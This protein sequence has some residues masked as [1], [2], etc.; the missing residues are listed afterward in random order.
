M[1]IK[2]KNG[3]VTGTSK[4]DKI[5]WISSKDWKKAL[6]V[7][8]GGGNDVINFKK[9]KYKNKLNGQAGND[10]IYGGTSY[11][12]IHGNAG[13][14]V[15][16]GYNGTD[17]LYG[18]DGVDK[19]YGGNGNDY[20]YG[21]KGNDLLDGGANNDK[22]YG[23]YGTNTLKGGAGNDSIYGGTGAD[24]IYAGTGS[25]YI[26]A[27]KGTNTLYFGSNEGTNTVVKGGGTDIIYFNKTANLNNITAYYSDNNLI[28]N[29]SGTTVIIKDYKLG[30]HSAKYIQAG[31]TKKTIASFLDTAI[32]VVPPSPYLTVN[33]TRII[34]GTDNADT[35]TSELG[36]NRIYAGSGNDNITTGAG[37]NYV[38]GGTG[39][40]T[41]TCG[42]ETDIIYG[43]GGEN[44]IYISKG[45]GTD[46]TYDEN[47]NTFV[48]KDITN[49]DSLIFTGGAQN[50]LGLYADLTIT[51]YGNNTDSLTI[52]DFFNIEGYDYSKIKLQAGT[53]GEAVSLYELINNSD[54]KKYYFTGTYKP[55]HNSVTTS[56]AQKAAQIDSVLYGDAPGIS[57]HNYLLGTAGGNNTFY[58]GGVNEGLMGHTNGGITYIIGGDGDETF[59]A[60]G[61]KIYYNGQAYENRE[62]L[63]VVT[64]QDGTK[65][66]KNGVFYNTPLAYEEPYTNYV[67]S[68]G[69]SYPVYYTEDSNKISQI[70]EHDYEIKRGF[71]S[72]NSNNIVL[73]EYIKSSTG[74]IDGGKGNDTFYTSS[75]A[76]G[77]DGN[78]TL[79]GSGVM[80]GNRGDDKFIVTDEYDMVSELVPMYYVC[81]NSGNDYIDTTEMS[82]EFDGTISIIFGEGVNTLKVDGKH[83]IN[84]GIDTSSTFRE[85]EPVSKFIE[86]KDYVTDS[87]VH[88][89]AF[90][91]DNK[92]YIASNNGR[93]AGTLIIDGWGQLTDEQKDKITITYK[94]S[95]E[96]LS[97]E[98]STYTLR[99][100]LNVINQT[101]E[102]FEGD[103]YTNGAHKY[104]IGNGA[105]I[106]KKETYRFNVIDNSNGALDTIT[107]GET[108]GTLGTST[109]ANRNIYDVNQEITGT[110]PKNVDYYIIGGSGAQVIKGGDG[111]DVIY[112]NNLN[113]HDADGNYIYAAENDGNDTIYGGKG[114]DYIIGGS[115]NDFIDG[116]SGKDYID[117][118]EGD[119][120]LIGGT[121]EALDLANTQF[122]YKEIH[123]GNGN[124]TIYSLGAYS[125]GNFDAESS[126]TYL[127]GDTYFTNNIYAGSGND[128]IHAN[129]YRDVVYGGK[130]NDTIYSYATAID[131]YYNSNATSEIYGEEG[132]DSIILKSNA[133]VRAYGGDGDDIIDGSEATA[134]YY[135]MLWGDNGNDTIY[136][137]NSWDIIYTGLGNNYVEAGAG[138]DEIHGSDMWLGQGEDNY[139]DAGDGNDYIRTSGTST[140]F[141]GAGN[142]T[143]YIATG[144]ANVPSNLLIDG[145]AGDDKYIADGEYGYDTIVASSGNDVIE[146]KAFVKTNTSYQYN[147]NDLVLSYNTAGLIL[148]DYASGGFS[149]FTIKTYDGYAQNG[150][151]TMADFISYLNGSYSMATEG[152]EGDDAISSTGNINGLGGN[153]FIL[154]HS[155]TSTEENPQIINTGS[156]NNSVVAMA[157]Y[158]SITGG[159][160][161]DE[162]NIQ[163]RI[164][165]L[166]DN[167]GNNTITAAPQGNY[168]YY[169]LNITLN[170]NGDNT[171]TSTENAN[172]SYYEINATG[173]GKQTINVYSVG[174]GNI[175]I[176]DGNEYINRTLKTEIT[177]GSGNDDITLFE[178]I[179][180]SGIGNDTIAVK[181]GAGSGSYNT[182]G[183]ILKGEDGN[184]TYIIEGGHD[185][186]GTTGISVNSKVLI[187]DT[188]GTNDVK[189]TSD[190]MTHDNLNLLLNVKADGTLEEFK[191]YGDY[192]LETE[193][194]DI[195]GTGY[196]AF[197]CGDMD[198]KYAGTVSTASCNG[199]DICDGVRFANTETV[200]NLSKIEAADGYYISSTTLSSI[201][202][203]AATWLTA[204][205]REYASVWDAIKPN[206]QNDFNSDNY[207]ALYAIFNNEN[208]W[209]QGV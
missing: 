182:Y 139:I 16:Y 49:L 143:I 36:T 3:K 125:E 7:N 196:S 65:E 68:F 5:T 192:N 147:G 70:R 50:S 98:N 202:E 73:V 160:G 23:N 148:K 180:N 78:D 102:L 155:T 52:K 121:V 197:I 79:K 55:K 146:F 110:V 17:H 32:P 34:S 195:T 142:D 96:W 186:Q 164:T 159:T 111:N 66:I 190:F 168:E 27:G 15:I 91:K 107:V 100:F 97:N 118:G 1:A 170:G 54:L 187:T 84:I 179:V 115:G 76:N 39:N 86:T 178:G 149:N 88:F 208:T 152:T 63:I 126:K 114:N 42:S 6:T 153:D 203:Q 108:A 184:D 165:T 77:G 181:D 45:S 71:L 56:P 132:N 18:D 4:K 33:G 82:D 150:Q 83:N 198:L 48:F 92:L 46:V 101:G 57:S 69:E 131:T 185:W 29:A 25:D 41:I 137:S 19:L 183:A 62:Y 151:Y 145:G 201:M 8:A 87:N 127:G 199:W 113:G 14:D 103:G 154:A 104:D 11:D 138:D 157:D 173:S 122:N 117:G 172:C 169:L 64:K 156:G 207:N 105:T 93:G 109:T 30:G 163:S 134:I 193:E 74:S 59:H 158:S 37:Y 21:G 167:G 136:G 161:N 89:T 174:K 47:D 205:G 51:G 191:H 38:Y 58:S 106:R 200:N 128:E 20:L 44:T 75:G 40:D 140:V 204:E 209:T 206:G 61:N 112:G 120:I 81:T 90:E 189:F 133:D 141:G 60:E 124:N 10:T 24:K 67:D 194:Y 13:N 129:A 26:N 43:G 9:S 130:G 80:Y 72:D 175:S 35:L 28:L 85:E 2:P 162:Y 166:V 123:G 144:Y 176:F 31:S 95:H 188:E 116:G 119:D 12:T 22:I 94:E 53:N 171:I 99:A 177:T 135:N